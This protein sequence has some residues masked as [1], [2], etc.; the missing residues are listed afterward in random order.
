MIRRV[1]FVCMGNICRSP[2]AEGIAR[3]AADAAG[4]ALLFDSAGTLSYHA[5]EAPDP[6]AREVARERGTPIDAQR[7]RQVRVADFTD[8]D[9]ILAADRQNLAELNR[10]RPPD[11]HAELALLR[12][13]CGD[14]NGSEVPDPYYGDVR[15]FVAVHTMLTTAMSGLLRRVTTTNTQ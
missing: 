11:A 13:W 7:A 2:L 5:G 14:P 1:L 3:A 15:D 10:L 4:M 8:F 12:E 9:L 6:R